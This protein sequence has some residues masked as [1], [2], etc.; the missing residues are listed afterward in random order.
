[1]DAT[2]SNGHCI[3]DVYQD[4]ATVLLSAIL[5]PGNRILLR[6]IETYE[7]EG[8]RRSRVHHKSISY[9]AAHSALLPRALARLRDLAPR[10]RLNVFF[11]VCPRLGGRGE[12]DL[13]FQIRQVNALWADVD[14]VTVEA[15][16]AR[17]NEADL[18]R[19]SAVVSSGSG[20]HL[21][22]LLNEPH[23]IDDASQPPPV[24]TE[25]HENGNGKKAVRYFIDSAGQRVEIGPH[26]RLPVLSPKA[27]HVQDILQ[28]IA[29]AI[30]G[31]N[32]Q[33]LSRLLRVPGFQNRKNE[34]NGRAPLPCTLI[35]CEPERRYPIS[36][37]EDFAKRSPAYKKRRDLAVIPLPKSRKQLPPSRQNKLAE[38][39]AVC[40]M[41]DLGDRS[42]CDFNFCTYAI[43]EGV[44]KEHASGLVQNV[45]KFAEGGERYF[46]ITWQAAEDEVREQTYAR[47]KKDTA[48]TSGTEKNSPSKSGR[49]V[50][51]AANRSII[52]I[53]P[54]CQQLGNVL[55]K[56]T[57]ALL[58]TGTCFRRAEQ[59]VVVHQGKSCPIMKPQELAGEL[60]QHLEFFYGDG[61]SGRYGALTPI[62]ASTW[63][64]NRAQQ[65]RLPE[66]RIFTRNPVF[67]EDWRLAPPGF[68]P[69]TGIYYAGQAIQPRIET[70]FLDTLLS[71]FCW[72]SNGDRTNYIAMLLTA[73]LAPRFVGSK[74][75]AIFNGNQSN[76]GK[77]ILAQIIAIIRD[78]GEVRTATYNT[79]DEEFEKRL[80]SL[81]RS[82]ATTI[83]IDNAKNASGR[84]ATI[85]SACLERSITDSILSFRLLSESADIT[86]ENSHI[87]C[88]TANAPEASRDLINR[89]V[90]INL[91]HEGDPTHRTF[92]IPDPEGYAKEHRLEILGELLG[93]V[94]RWKA[95]KM[96]HSD[97]ESRFNK[98]GWAQIIG[99]I[100][101]ACDDPDF[102][103]NADEAAEEFDS[104]RAAVAEFIE[105]LANVRAADGWSSKQLVWAADQHELLKEELGS[106]S[107]RSRSTRMGK[108]L[109]RFA[110]MSE[111]HA[112][113]FKISKERT[114]ML[115][116]ES[117]KDGAVYKVGIIELEERC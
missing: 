39:V 84:N 102:M 8:R 83:I 108:L 78:G 24:K 19:P 61:E 26:T 72:K 86:C 50:V 5:R 27:Q 98:R 73:V 20:V 88:I 45:G 59:T 62:Y 69:T 7:E 18:P 47:I 91:F 109:S 34:R 46:E 33:D 54:S 52:E 55:A 82:G 95:A 10:H 106:G 23:E 6:P 16:L 104:T 57:D 29:S 51:D 12:Y 58:Q 117:K 3:A 70:A 44:S 116:K 81:V 13:A 105:I 25:W 28:G 65:S 79:N 115:I 110:A 2:A 114:A 93:M 99:G 17:V 111:E 21:Y 92:E 40:A 30:G 87:F 14:N 71:E 31:D 15:T 56:I 112:E 74:P 9:P 101:Q 75:G 68:D 107:D 63:L 77:T 37:F 80:G 89:C 97:K 76:L 35:E 38:L 103:E 36:E 48:R 66:I 100:L 96:P 53:T 49:A 43:R 67:T 4:E 22:W 41:A 32:T 11:G 90:V 94:E 42:E 60:S 64:Y 1:M 85:S 113:R